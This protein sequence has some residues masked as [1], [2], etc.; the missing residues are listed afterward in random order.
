MAYTDPKRSIVVAMILAVFGFVIG[1]ITFIR[2]ASI[3]S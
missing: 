3:P 1:R 2:N